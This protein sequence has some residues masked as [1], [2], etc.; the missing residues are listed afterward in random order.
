MPRIEVREV[1]KEYPGVRALGGV[2]LDFAPGEVHGVIGENGAGKSTLMK[3]L[4]GVERATS[5]SVCVNEEEC[6]FRGVQDAMRA[7]I[8]MIHQELNL[9]D[10][11]SVAANLFLGRE[12]NFNFEAQEAISTD[13]VAEIGD[14]PS[15]A[16]P[17]TRGGN[18]EPTINSHRK[19]G[20]VLAGIIV[21][22]IA[23]EQEAKRWLEQVGAEFGAH[24]MVGSLSLAEKQL[25]E[26]AK[27]VSTG[28]EILI[29][30]EPTAVLSLREKEALFGLVARLKG[31]EKTVILISHLLGELI[32][33]CDRISVLR[34]GE[35]V[36]T[37]L[38]GQIDERGL[39]GMMVGRELGEMYPAIPACGSGVVFRVKFKDSTPPQPLPKLGEGNPNDFANGIGKGSTEISIRRGEV[40]GFAGLIGSGRTELWESIL[41]LRR[42]NLG[43]GTLEGE[44]VR[45]RLKEWNEAGVIYV[46]EDRKGAGL[47]LDFS[48]EDN[49]VL[50]WLSR[51]GKIVTGKKRVR[52]SAETWQEKLAIKVP[53]VGDRVGSL[54]GGNQQKVSL[55][56]WLEGDPKV[57][58]L[59]EPTRGVDVGSKAQIYEIIAGLAAEGKAVVVISSEMQEV[60]GLCHRVVVMRDG[61]PVGILERSELSEN[62][63]MEFAA[64]VS[65]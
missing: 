45:R 53:S 58:V 37:V 34:D 9:V 17:Q 49:V 10:D 56:K 47:H 18:S 28:A 54:S 13:L 61:E 55:A 52:D 21:N 59:D 12:G 32:E 57:I 62:R 63:I 25:V 29:M 7:G 35:F 40:L 43:S 26:I 60:I 48:V 3:I 5:G 41:G 30:D 16:P 44:S 42:E 27:A 19:R 1:V 46:S 15:P 64:G 50:P 39:A 6:D 11:L 20:K 8:V 38:A 24:R 31:E 23:Q 33:N 22:K 51:F 65:A 36:G 2:S 4:A 14:N